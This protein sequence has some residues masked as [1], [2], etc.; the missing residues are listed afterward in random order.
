MRSLFFLICLLL[1]SGVLAEP[2]A[3]TEQ[4]ARER[5]TAGRDAYQQGHYQDA[6]TDFQLSYDLSQRPALLYNLGLAA[7]K[8]GKVREALDAF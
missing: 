4:L 5:F 3:Q 6:Y 7:Q 2:D 1:A 8:L